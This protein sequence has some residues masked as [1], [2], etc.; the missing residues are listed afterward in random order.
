MAAVHHCQNTLCVISLAPNELDGQTKHQFV[1]S[2]FF[3]ITE[4][5]LLIKLNILTTF[6]TYLPLHYHHLIHYD[7]CHCMNYGS[8]NHCPHFFR[9][10]QCLS[11]PLALWVVPWI[12]GS[13]GCVKWTS[14]YRPFTKCHPWPISEG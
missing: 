3:G 4:V 8:P 2:S 7:H 6:S 13:E 14:T 9:R 5:Y 1:T 10:H 11:P 12:G